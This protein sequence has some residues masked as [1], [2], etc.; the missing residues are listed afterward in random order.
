[1]LRVGIYS[2]V[3]EKEW[4]AGLHPTAQ[5]EE[6]RYSLGD[7][8]YSND[9]IAGSLRDKLVT[10]FNSIQSPIIPE[11]VQVT[12][13]IAD[14]QNFTIQFSVA[15]TITFQTQTG[16]HLAL[17]N[18]GPHGSVYP[19]ITSGSVVI[20]RGILETYSPIGELTG[21]K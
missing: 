4:V 19:D 10:F 18:F 1:M 11:S 15:K 12:D 14:Q 6:S 2:N 20:E 5:A 9:Q 16:S 17:E 21:R 8:S 3:A 7:C 13:A